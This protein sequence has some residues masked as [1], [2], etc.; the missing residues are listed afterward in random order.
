MINDS[1]N[2]SNLQTAIVTGAGSGL[3]RALAVRL[4]RD[5]WRV[6]VAD[7]DFQAALQTTAMI[8]QL[9][10]GVGWA[11]QLDVSS[12]GSWERLHEE[13]TDKCQQIDLLVNNAGILAS[14]EIGVLPVDD[15]RKVI[16]TNLFGCILG[17]HMFVDWLKRNPG[18]HI[19]NV[20]SIMGFVN[21]PA[22]GAYNVSKSGVISFSETL[23]Q[24]LVRHNVGVSVACPAFFESNLVPHGSYSNE[25][26]HQA[27]HFEMG[28]A[29][30]T[31]D[32]LADILVD[33]VT[34]RRFYVFAPFV[35]SR[36]A[37]FLKRMV[38]RFFLRLVEYLGR[39]RLSRAKV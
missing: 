30:L 26:E 5:N 22:A 14:G 13:L 32:R 35:A 24:E 1:A 21:P 31:A 9:E 16:D 8:D 18:S 11:F 7:I 37:W 3:G 39:R 6:A 29:R 34:K 28:A 20:A 33:A 23:F 36:G 38:P 15:W 2:S 12:H 19:L 4:A 17:C 27:A 25:S 10:T